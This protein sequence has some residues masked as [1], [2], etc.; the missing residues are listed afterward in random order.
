MSATYWKSAGENIARGLGEKTIRKLGIGGKFI[1]RAG[2]VVGIGF[3]A[4]ELF[5][6]YKE[7]IEAEPAYQE[8]RILQGELEKWTSAISCLGREPFEDRAY[9][10]LEEGG[11]INALYPK[12]SIK[13]SQIKAADPKEA[14]ALIGRAMNYLRQTENL[15]DDEDFTPK[16]EALVARLRRLQLRL[17][18]D[19]DRRPIQKQLAQIVDEIRPIESGYAARIYDCSREIQKTLGSNVAWAAVSMT[20]LG[21]VKKP[22]PGQ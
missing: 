17:S 18:R 9:G 6:H 20:T 1:G 5:K 19:D 2:A 7:N 15:L 10:S 4:Y 22:K 13:G 8:M 3:L 14:Y 11:A 21:L 16:T 12:Q